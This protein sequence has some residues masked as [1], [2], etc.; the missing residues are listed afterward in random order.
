MQAVQ[1]AVAASVGQTSLSVYSKPRVGVL[2]TGDEIVAPEETPAAGQIRDSN[3]IMLVSQLRRMDCHMLDMGHVRDEK[4]LIAQRITQGMANVDVL[5][6]S[7]GMSMGKYDYAP[8]VLK[9]LGVELLITKVRIK[10]GKPFVLGE[11]K[12]T[13]GE[14][15]CIWPT[16]KPSQCNDLHVAVGVS[17]AAAD[18]GAAGEGAVGGR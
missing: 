1:L 10:P 17:I 9:E 3:S 4:D 15:I 5:F 11:K 8:Q 7:G 12:R 6:I 13:G 18:A 14:C 16:R 2:S